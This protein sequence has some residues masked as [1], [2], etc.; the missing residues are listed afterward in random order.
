M[1]EI[2]DILQLRKNSDGIS[3]TFD[4]TLPNI[5]ATLNGRLMT[6]FKPFILLYILTL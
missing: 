2:I 3:I 4:I 5:G 1:Q 6:T